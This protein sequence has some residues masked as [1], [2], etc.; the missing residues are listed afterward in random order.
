MWCLLI[1]Q[2]HSRAMFML[3][4]IEANHLP[5]KESSDSCEIPISTYYIIVS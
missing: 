4:L 1:R 5:Y 3:C 2:K